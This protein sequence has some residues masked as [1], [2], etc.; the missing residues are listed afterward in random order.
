MPQREPVV[1]GAGAEVR[2]E[3]DGVVL[4]GVVVE[5]TAVTAR[6]VL[7]V[8]TRHLFP[9]EGGVVGAVPVV[10]EVPLPGGPVETSYGRARA[11]VE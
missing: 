8:S 6:V 9:V 10:A 2:F 11:D 4:Y 1:P 7:V 3:R 5:A